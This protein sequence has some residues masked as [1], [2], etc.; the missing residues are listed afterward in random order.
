[1]GM[2][3]HF[4]I[5]S[6]KVKVNDLAVQIQ[7]HTVCAFLVELSLLL[8]I[9]TPFNSLFFSFCLLT[10]SYFLHFEHNC[11]EFLCYDKIITLITNI[12]SIIY[13]G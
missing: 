12:T 2:L 10:P 13:K 3:G 4:Q 8:Q 7:T 9:P 5:E 11:H 6:T 1:M